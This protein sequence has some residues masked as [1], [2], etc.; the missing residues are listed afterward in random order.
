MSVDV[1]VELVLLVGDSGVGV[2]VC[3]VEPALVV[4]EVVEVLPG[5]SGHE[6]DLVAV[7]VMVVVGEELQHVVVVERVAGVP[8]AHA[9]GD[10]VLDEAPV[11]GHRAAPAVGLPPVGAEPEVEGQVLEAVDLVVY[12]AAQ[13]PA[14]VPVDGVAGLVLHRVARSSRSGHELVAAAGGLDVVAVVGSVVD[15]A[16]LVVEVHGERGVERRRGAVA[17]ARRRIDIGVDL[18]VERYGEV[19]V[20]EVGVQAYV[21]GGPVVP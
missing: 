8:C 20:K 17:R 19:L 1:A 9:R 11:S 18:G 13:G 10:S 3:V 7:E 15:A 21:D 2:G 6:V 4:V 12:G 5:V 16:V 14:E